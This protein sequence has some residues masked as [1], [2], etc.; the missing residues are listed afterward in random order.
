[1]MMKKQD[2]IEEMT[3]LA[4]IHSVLSPSLQKGERKKRPKS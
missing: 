3:K 1:L 2:G 4:F